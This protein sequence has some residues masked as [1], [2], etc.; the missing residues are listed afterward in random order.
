MREVDS[1]WREEYR[2]TY[3]PG[4]LAERDAPSRGRPAG[5]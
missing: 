2:S 5:D 3:W 1:H 4:I